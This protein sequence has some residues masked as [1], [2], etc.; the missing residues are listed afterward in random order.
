MDQ[1]CNAIVNHWTVRCSK[2]ST[3]GH[4]LCPQPK[5]PKSLDRW[6]SVW[7]SDV[8]SADQHVAQDVDRPTIVALPRFC[9]QQDWSRIC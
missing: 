1:Q 3:S 2:L 9:N 4:N 7:Q 5:S 6:P 8:A